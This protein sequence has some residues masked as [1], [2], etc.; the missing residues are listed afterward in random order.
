MVLPTVLISTNGCPV[1]GLIICL[2]K[3][4]GT[5]ILILCDTARLIERQGTETMAFDKGVNSVDFALVNRVRPRDIA[6]TQD[7]GL[8]TMC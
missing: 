8:A 3:G 6:I 2:C 7:Y 1:V 5:L 4:L